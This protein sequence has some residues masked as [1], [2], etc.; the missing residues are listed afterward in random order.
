MGDFNVF[1][2]VVVV[3]VTLMVLAFNVYLLVNYQHPDDR[4]QAWLPKVVVITG[5]SVAMLSILMLPADIANQHACQHSVYT[6]ACSYT[7]PMRELWY[8]VYILDAVLVFFVIP[9]AIFYYEGDQE[10]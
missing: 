8:T 5:L 6:T 3:V 4:N 7:L 10:K 9:F 1:L 2:L